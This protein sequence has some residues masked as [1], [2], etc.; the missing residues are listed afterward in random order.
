MPDQ[1]FVQRVRNPGLSEGRGD[2]ILVALSE[3]DLELWIGWILRPEEFRRFVG[4]PPADDAVRT[5]R[6]ALAFGG[7]GGAR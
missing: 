7:K 3:E 5:A 6:V 4:E 2:Y 1:V